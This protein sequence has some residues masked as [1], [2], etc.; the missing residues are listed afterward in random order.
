MS[1]FFFI[2]S[3]QSGGE[4]FRISHGC[5]RDILVGF[6]LKVKILINEGVMVA[7]L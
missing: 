4:L 2:R 3:S 7:E 1:L 6:L 5:G